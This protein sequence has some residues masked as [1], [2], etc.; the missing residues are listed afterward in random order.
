MRYVGTYQY[1]IK[2]SNLLWYPSLACF[3]TAKGPVTTRAMPQ[4]RVGRT[5]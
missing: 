3:R 2:K 5:K 4:V 1:E